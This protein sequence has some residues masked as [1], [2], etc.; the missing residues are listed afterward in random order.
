MWEQPCNTL[1]LPVHDPASGYWQ[2]AIRQVRL[3]SRIVDACS[4]GCH[5]VVG[6]LATWDCSKGEILYAPPP[7]PILASFTHTYRASFALLGTPILEEV[8]KWIS[9]A[10]RSWGQRNRATPLTAPT[11]AQNPKFVQNLSRRLFFGVR[12]GHKF[13][14][15]KRSKIWKNLSG[16][17]RFFSSEFRQ[18]LTNLG[19]FVS[20]QILDKLGVRGI[21]ECCKGP[22]ASQHLFW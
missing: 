20:G 1:R 13:E 21:L 3:G 5:G 16:N 2:V 15:K 7:P 4:H 14:K 11:N 19:P 10:S 12:G 8:C 6:P 9:T 18:I 17:C 22:E